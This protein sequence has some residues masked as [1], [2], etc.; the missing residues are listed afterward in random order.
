MY[1]RV[2][3]HMPTVMVCSG[4]S[5]FYTRCSCHIQ[6]QNKSDSLNN[7]KQVYLK[8]WTHIL[9]TTILNF[10]HV[11]NQTKS[12]LHGVPQFH[13][14]SDGWALTYVT[15]AYFQTIT[16]TYNLGLA[17]SDVGYRVLVPNH[18]IPPI[19]SVCQSLTQATVSNFWTN[20][21]Y[22]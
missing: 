7:M 18:H 15:V 11:T 4:G 17:E 22:L 2:S 1:Y 3:L 12:G 20:A 19:I 14:L 13:R 21:F 6:G 9:Q 5:R 8:C 10:Y 16:S